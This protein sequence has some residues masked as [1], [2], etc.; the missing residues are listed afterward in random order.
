MDTVTITR[1][2]T[3]RWEAVADDRIAG[4][5]DVAHRPD[6]RLFISI[7]VWQDALFDRLAAAMLAELPQPLHTL[8]AEDDQDLTA[9]WERLGFAPGRRER[10]YVLLTDPRDTGL[11]ALRLPPG[12]TILPAGAA[13]E[14]P[15]RAL[16][17]AIRAEVEADAGWRTMPAEVLPA[18]AGVLPVDPSKHAVAVRDGEYVGLVRVVPV[19]TR[20]RIGLLAI[21]AGQRRH[22]IGRALLAHALGA[23]HRDGIDSAWAEIDES[24]TAAIALAEGV[25]GRRTGGYLELVRH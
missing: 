1:I 11:G 21:R 17:R 19:R 10:E 6:G 23:L 8:V 25:G 3:T 9:R 18:P 22:G 5:G 16:D 4:H 2:A 15:L 20:A 13:D 12:V 14:S 7:D 24:N